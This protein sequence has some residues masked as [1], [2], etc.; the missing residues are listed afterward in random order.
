MTRT[1]FALA[2]AASTAIVTLAGAPPALAADPECRYVMPP[3]PPPPVQADN[4]LLQ[5]GPVDGR[6]DGTTRGLGVRLPRWSVVGLRP[7]GTADYDLKVFHCPDERVLGLSVYGAGKVDFVALDGNRSWDAAST[8]VYA[9]YYRY[10]VSETG[11]FNAEYSTG[12]EPLPPGTSQTLALRGTPAVVRD[13][14]V[15]AGTTTTIRLRV[16]TGSADLFLVDSDPDKSTWAR[17]RVQSIDSSTNLGS[18]DESITISL[19]AGVR[20]KTYGLVITN[21]VDYGEYVVVR[22]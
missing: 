9:R 1:L 21:N 15:A 20:S 14:F 7:H 4:Q 16:L 18:A 12:G 22:S 11:V 3:A 8:Q 17:T 19:P 2:L 13:V 6:N 5:L 10:P